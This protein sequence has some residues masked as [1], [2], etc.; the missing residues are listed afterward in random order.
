MSEV[1]EV[2]GRGVVMGRAE[3]VALVADTTLSFWGEVDA[4]TGKVIGVGHPLE[5]ESL[6]GRVL[7]IRSTKGS[8]GTP[9]TL[10]LAKL[11]GTAPV[12]FINVE[13]DSLAALGCI[14]N[15]IP[16]ITDLERNP[17]TTIRTGDRVL[18]DALQGFVRVTRHS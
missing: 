1:F 6:Q 4:V 5:G 17:F 3:G 2:R 9:M 15:R 14:V 10:N 7:V 8:S 18:V 12:A 13:V 11:E 16:M